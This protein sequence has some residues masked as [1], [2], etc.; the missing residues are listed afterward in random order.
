MRSWQTMALGVLALALMPVKASEAADLRVDYAELAGLVGS[1]VS[2]ATVHIHN[3]PPAFLFSTIQPS[4]AQFRGTKSPV[5][6]PPERFSRFGVTYAYYVRDINSTA[7]T[8]SAVEGALR[9]TV[10]FEEEGVELAPSE[11]FLPSVQWSK[12]SIDIDL[13]PER[14]GSSVTLDVVRVKVGGRTRAECAQ[15]DFVQR[16]TCRTVAYLAR[17][18]IDGV[19][20]SI[21]K[22]L[23]DALKKGTVR[24]SIA[25]FM[26]N[27][28]TLGSLGDVQVR[29]ISTDARGIVV[30]FC[31]REC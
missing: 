30:S 26:A 25:S 23:T 7:V 17:E 6:V 29:D 11:K 21:E 5:D 27:Y 4:F 20:A 9:V 2:D 14:L 1:L 24:S 3:E 15:T 31:L 19:Q 13:R 28:L 10:L 22:G 12:P 8:V 16:S 18:K